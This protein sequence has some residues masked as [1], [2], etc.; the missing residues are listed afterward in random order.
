MRYTL[1]VSTAVMTMAVGSVASPIENFTGFYS[2]GDS[3]SD[4]GKLIDAALNPLSDE[5]RFSNGPV[6]AELLA[7]Q[8]NNAGLSTEN[9]ALGGAT[10]QGGDA[11]TAGLSNFQGQRNA[12]NL[13][14]IGVP[15]PFDLPLD[16]GRVL[17]L[18]DPGSNPLASVWFGA[19]DLLG[20]NALPNREE[21]A[22]NAADAVTDG[23]FEVF[24]STGG[25]FDDFLIANLPDIGQTPLFQLDAFAAVRAGTA[26]QVT[27]A[28]VAFN[29]QLGL[30]IDGLRA[31]GLNVFELD[32]FS[33]FNQALADPLG[34]LGEFDFLDVTTPC[35]A[36]FGIVDGPSCLDSPL[37]DEDGVN[38]FLFADSIH[39]TAGTHEIIAS[40]AS[41]ALAPV[42][43][44]A[45]MPLMFAGLGALVVLRKK[46][47]A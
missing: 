21:L 26:A 13:N 16:P 22:R 47:A 5:G 42:P 24:Q 12:F 10:A 33:L 7:Q 15:I 3:L 27:D 8:F 29:E 6:W 25:L 2:F 28:T 41:A 44:P 39:P 17:Q 43:L 31:R 38:S 19:N 18:G 37:I 34:P 9:Y 20:Q 11:T 4:D 45:G 46:R 32:T 40:Q 1:V 30:N 14:Q 36:S 35:T 23:V